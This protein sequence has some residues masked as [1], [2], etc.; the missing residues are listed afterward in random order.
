MSFLDERSLLFSLLLV[1]TLLLHE[2]L[3][4]LAIVL[5]EGNIVISN[6]VVA[7]LARRFGCFAIAPL[8]PSQHGLADV[9]ASV[10]HDICLNHLVSI[11]RHH[12]RQSPSEQIVADVTE[13]EGFVGVGR[14][15]LYHHERA[16]V[17]DG[18]EAELGVRLYPLEQLYPLTR[19]DAEVEEALYGIECA[20]DLWHLLLQTFANL[21]RR[22]VWSL[23]THLGKGEHNE[24]YLSLELG[25][26]L[27]QLHHLIGHL[28]TVKLFHN[29]LHG[30]C[31]LCFNLHVSLHYYI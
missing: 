11:G 3:H 20:D 12:L 17:C 18:Q 15:V 13:V 6:E 2:L 25:P 7:L 30:L 23:V 21:L 27:L 19:T 8:Q 29:G 10:V 22:S 31:Y 4:F 14:R 5:I 26:R 16:V 28:L 9:D 1:H 24:G